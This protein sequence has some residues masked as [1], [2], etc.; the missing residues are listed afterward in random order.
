MG[1]K[2]NCAFLPGY[3]SF[4]L[5]ISALNSSDGGHNHQLKYACCFKAHTKPPLHLKR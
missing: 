3:N 4:A 2:N 1:L 5:V